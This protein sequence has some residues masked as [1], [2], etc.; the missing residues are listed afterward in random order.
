MYQTDYDFAPRG[1]VCP[2]CG[3]VYS[4]TTPICFYCADVGKPTT[5]TSTTPNKDFKTTAI[6]N[7]AVWWKDYL[8]QS[9][10]CPVGG[11]DYWDDNTHCWV[12][13]SNNNSNE[14]KENKN[15]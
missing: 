9:K 1:W 6:P 11:S 7:D 10:T 5:G 12:N 3:R 8:N 15:E 4:P 2:K 14:T 13:I